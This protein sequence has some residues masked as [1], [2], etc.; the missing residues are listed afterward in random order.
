M[1]L[2]KF[3]RRPLLRMTEDPTGAG[4]GD[5]GGG[6]STSSL[7]TG[8]GAPGLEGGGDPMAGGGEQSASNPWD[9]V[10]R[11]WKQE[12]AP[13]WQKT[14]AE[15]RR[16]IHQREQDVEKGI[17]T[18]ADGHGRYSK[19]RQ[20]FEPVLQQNPNLDL[21]GVYSTLAQNHLAL[22]QADPE[23]RR[24]LFMQMAQHYGVDFAQAAANGT[25][26]PTDGLTAAQKRELMAML[27]PVQS[28]VKSEMT[29]RQQQA[30]EQA[31]KSVDAFFSDPKNK[32]V[33]EVGSVMA[34]IVQQGITR[35]L[36]EAYELAILRSP[37]IRAKYIADM[38]AGVSA[39]APSPSGIG[40]VK[41]SAAPAS[42]GKPATID[43]TMDAVL[44]KHGLKR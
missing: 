34:Q 21:D 20:V 26:Q 27:E 36:G 1:I 32:Y 28:F 43:E 2:S 17:R 25:G 9:S 39:P 22:V 3:A 30:A 19:L 16:I 15:V 40:N 44:A 11:S 7:P 33:N 5:T 38:A 23:S 8:S 31:K 6:G 4:G 14:D 13:L 10:P 42:T 41:S 35:D 18:Y 37:E 29:T 12:Y 24:E